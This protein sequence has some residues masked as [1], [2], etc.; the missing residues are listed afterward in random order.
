MSLILPSIRFKQN[1]I[2]MYMAVIPIRKLESFSVD[3]WDPKNIAKRRGYQR[4]PDERRINN[5]AKYFEKSGAIMPV[6]GLVNVREADKLKYNP[7]R[8]E[9]VIPDGVNV[10]VVDMQHRLKGLI[11]ALEDGLIKDTFSFPI[12]ITEG[13]NQVRE[14]AQFYVINTKAKKM[15][16]ALTR[17]LLIE[18]NCIKEISDVKP[19]EVAAVQMT[20]DMNQSAALRDNPWYK[21]IR[22]PNEE[23]LHSHI[24]TEKSFVSSLRQLLITKKYKQTHVAA[25]RLAH[26]WMAIKENVPEAFDDP[27]RYAIQ[28]TPGM[29]AFNFFIA[30]RFLGQY[31]DKD[32]AKQLSGLK[33]LGADFWK[34][35]NKRGA[36]RFGTGMSGYS[37]LADHVKKFL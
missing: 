7:R 3:R 17:R 19:W 27:R 9:L 33:R 36:R 4:N 15:D 16:V 35:S 28:R 26:F 14:A 29:F 13:M 2:I 32:F 30:P 31:K 6:A 34:R 12:V 10:W 24:A 20:I 18:N 37:N 25:K 21:A 1:K 11:K 8:K 23:R 22:Q 5:I